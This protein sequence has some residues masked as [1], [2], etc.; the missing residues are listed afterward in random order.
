MG[1]PWED[2]QQTAELGPW[3]DFQSQPV[4]KVQPDM[5]GSFPE[6][7]AAMSPS[8]SIGQKAWQMAQVPSQMASRGLNAL[9]SAIPSPEPTGNMPLDLAKGTPRILANTLAEAAPKFVDR[10]SLLTAGASKVAS[11]SLPVL[12]SVGSGIANQVDSMVGTKPGAIKAAW[13]DASTIFS[14][15]KEAAKPLYQ[16]AQSEV[17]PGESLFAGMYKPD[18]IVDAAK[19]YVSKGGKLE[20]SEALTW[21]KAIDSLMGKRGYVKDELLRMREQADTMAK[22]SS[23][24]AQADPL[25]RKGLYGESLRNLIPQNKYGGA[26]AFKMALMAALDKIGGK[27]ALALLSPAAW[28]TAATAGGVVSRATIP[29]IT[30]PSA[31]VTIKNVLEEYLNRRDQSSSSEESR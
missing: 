30:K 4:Q 5:S 23:N 28:G 11:A 13:D 22:A 20:P 10:A 15:G 21:R 24:I 3:T 8:N 7:R 18:Q 31:A 27:P 26:S 29:I 6:A 14:R 17:A 9:A 2:Y 1:G 16:V 25:Y 12:Q 19:E